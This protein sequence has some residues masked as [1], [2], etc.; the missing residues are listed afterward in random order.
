MSGAEALHVLW[1]PKSGCGSRFDAVVADATAGRD[2]VALRD[3]A[4]FAPLHDKRLLFAVQLGQDGINLTYYRYLQWLRA[5]PDALDGCVGAVLVDAGSDQ[6]TKGVAREL[7]YAANA[8]GCAFIGRPLVEGTGTLQNFGTQAALAGSDL[9]TAYRAA[10]VD[11]TVRLLAAGPGRCE[12]PRLAVLHASN[13]AT[14]NTLA[15]WRLVREQLT[16]FTVDEI[17][18]RNGQVEDCAGC[19]YET[20]LHF[21]EKGLCFYGGTIVEKAYPAVLSA[22]AVVMLCPNYNDA[23]SAALTAF[24]NRLTALFR[25]R[26]FYDKRLYALV[27]SGY[28]GGDLV[29]QQLISAMNMNKSFYLPPRFSM[30]TIA[31]EP[32]AVLAQQNVRTLSSAFA[33]QMK[34]ELQER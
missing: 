18:L 16:D 11:L 20:C 2:C 19:P 7:V 34:A 26:R 33:A 32:R 9:P 22:D 4:L 13:S 5:H 28:S 3:E 17:S 25:V 24:I 21:G 1:M 29:A 14:S 23:L 27:V 30:Q 15:L 12:K 8:S 31:N 10:A 6:F